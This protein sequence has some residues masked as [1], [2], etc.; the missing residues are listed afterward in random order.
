MK[1]LLALVLAAVLAFGVCAC[2]NNTPVEDVSSNTETE[3]R[4]EA[5]QTVE[6]GKLIMATNATFPPYESVEGDEFVGIDVEISKA[7][8]Q[9]LGL[10][11]VIEDMEFDSIISSVKGGK[12]DFGAAGMT[13]SEERLEEVNFSNTY[14]NG[15]QVV[16]V[17][18]DS[19]IQSVDDLFAEGANHTIG[20]QL[21]TT[22]DIYSTED[23]EEAGLGT[24]ER[25][26]AGADAVMALKNGQIDCVIIDNEPAKAFVA[27]TEGLKILPAEYANEDYALCISKDNPALL[28][29]VNKALAELEADGTLKSIIDQFIKA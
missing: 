25:Y 22:G 29:A 19:D 2:T 18:E 28:E 17:A 13:V 4:E 5:L 20:V 16:I 15:V 26:S 7:I 3:S 27:A 23:I 14:A 10:E 21:A 11:L 12:A 1:K 6:A 8:A 24:I 9:K